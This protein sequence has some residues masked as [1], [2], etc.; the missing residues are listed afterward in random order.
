LNDSDS[1]IGDIESSSDS[2]IAIILNNIALMCM[3]Q[4]NYEDAEEL[5]LRA[6]DIYLEYKETN[7]RHHPQLGTSVENLLKIWQ[8]DGR[9]DLIEKFVK[10]NQDLFQYEEEEEES[11]ELESTIDVDWDED[12]DEDEV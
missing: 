7:G 9:N 2:H 1:S 5:L 4:F 12:E 8:Q 6:V 11:L 10:A 3:K